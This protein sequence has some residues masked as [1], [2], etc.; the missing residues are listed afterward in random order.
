MLPMTPRLEPSR[1]VASDAKPHG[2]RKFF[3]KPA[4]SRVP[5]A[6]LTHEIA[7]EWLRAQSDGL[8]YLGL[9]KIYRFTSRLYCTII[10]FAN[11]PFIVYCAIYCTQYYQ[12]LHPPPD[13]EVFFRCLEVFGGVF[14][15]FSG[16]ILDG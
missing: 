5:D 3:A 13:F 9:Y 6:S 16:R 8:V 10:L 7:D 11:T 15:L 2:A 12:L 1:L 4:R 14:L